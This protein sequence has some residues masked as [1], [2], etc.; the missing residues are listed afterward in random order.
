MRCWNCL[1]PI[2]DSEHACPDCGQALKPNSTQAANARSRLEYLLHEASEWDF[3]PPEVRA[4]LS[5]VYQRRLD[6]LQGLDEASE[7]AWPASDWSSPVWIRPLQ[8][9]PAPAP[10]PDS[11][12]P[13]SQGLVEQSLQPTGTVRDTVA[14]SRDELASLLP[15][16]SEQPTAAVA[17]QAQP[18]L[19]SPG[20]DSPARSDDSPL[21]ALPPT[22]EET[23]ASR[24]LGEADIRWFHSLGA[25]L[26]VAAVVGWLRATWDGY[27]KSLAGFMILL[28][29]AAMHGIALQLRKS[30]PLSARLLSILAGVL[31]PPAL[32]AVEIFD[33]LPPAVSGHDYW[34]LA[35]LVSASLLGLQA[36]TMK[37]KVPLYAGAVCTVMA[38]WSQG[39][40][41]TSVLCLLLGFVLG[42]VK[43][44]PEADE[45]EL[46][47]VAEL[48]KVGLA[49]GVFGC[50]ATL[51]L[52]RPE[53]APWVPLLAFTG[54]LIYLHLPTL[55]RQP[56]G[57]G[58]NRVA[59][60]AAITVLG[61]ALMR[62]ALDVPAPG[63]GL[64]ALLAAGLFLSARPEHEGGLLALRI[65]SVLGLVGLGIGFFTQ[66]HVPLDQT[67]AHPAESVM[68]FALAV[69]GAGLFGYLS[70]QTH[71]ESQ[72]TTLGLAALLATFGGW[73]H[74]FLL[75]CTP[76]H[77]SYF[78]HNGQ[79][80]PLLASFGLWVA[81][82]LLGSRWLRPRERALV[83]AVTAPVLLVATLVAGLSGLFLGLQAVVWSRVLF[84]LGAV[85]LAWER[86]LLVP[87]SEL[88]RD[89][90]GE[91]S[92]LPV[93][94]TRA[95]EFFLPRQVI[96]CLALGLA[97]AGSF[98]PQQ[99][100]IPMQLFGLVLLLS[101]ALAY[102]QPGLEM[103]WLVSPAALAV[104][105][106]HD[107]FPGQLLV[108]YLLA[109]A[110]WA[111]P[112][113]ARPVS[114]VLLVGL[115]ASVALVSIGE[116]AHWALLT[117]PMAYALAVATPV[118]GRGAW[119]KPVPAQYGF[120]LLLAVCL[121]CP[122]DLEPGGA[123]SFCLTALLPILAFLLGRGARHSLPG[124]FLSPTSPHALLLV[125][126]LWTLTQG[127]RESGL[128]LLV[129][130]AWAFQLDEPAT[131]KE[132]GRDLANGLAILGLAWMLGESH[133]H[134][135]LLVLAGGVLLS[136]GIA[137]S[138]PA[139][140]NPE[141]SD[142]ALLVWI[143][144]L[145]SQAPVASAEGG[146]A[147]L[148]GLVAGV[149]GLAGA[150]IPLILAGW[151]TFLKMADDQ[152]THL[153]ADF[154]IRLLPLAAVLIGSSL[155]MMARPEH[156]TRTALGV[157]PLATL[158][159]G[160]GLLA[161][162]PLLGLA[163]QADL[164]D[165][166]WVL[167]VGC[168]CLAVSQGFATLPELQRH[169]K[170]SGGWVLTGWAGVS[171]GRA[172]MALPWQLATLVVGL[173]LVAAGIK[174]EKS[175]KSKETAPP[176][177]PSLS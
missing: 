160:L 141:K 154:K 36:H 56:D 158:R 1:R 21:P 6:R 129:A 144:V 12:A 139:R 19:A 82:W 145:A 124:R 80:A 58:A 38:G 31:T 76:V 110:S 61:M 34:T 130:S 132:Y 168:S 25:L 116:A 51:F 64:Y 163:V 33:F 65:G 112:D 47:W 87:R 29:P 94:L 135:S 55:T 26:V 54:A 49:A 140:W 88:P 125:G 84:W 93:S 165:F 22:A 69:A 77:G 91:T 102:R 172:A 81:L 24:L 173:V 96:W 117:I 147:L 78:A 30:V 4:E 120:D 7:A 52:F 63:V 68:R 45:T 8:L 136:E 48:R 100:P 118:P 89:E 79:L 111:A 10:P 134:P 143:L 133:A 39:A 105:W 74:L 70:R 20:S 106:S 122:L 11:P 142:A 128:L 60:Q 162:P 101:P 150:R 114:L 46:A 123:P 151:L 138:V 119:S 177:P 14:L 57:S 37:E 35:F 23:L 32:L 104:Q 71:L 121:F 17:E 62:F 72:F 171:L 59:I 166:I 41:V 131:G 159:T 169:L 73:Y 66:A 156:P 5:G 109:A 108:F 103:A 164:T 126:F 44:G 42:P 95:L 9:G 15:A 99:I 75:A 176:D 53:Q 97:F 90:T 16:E 113:K 67:G 167:A 13:L 115:A 86:G 157:N 152:L 18:P 92:A 170:Q 85:A 107:P 27:G 137:L 149:R 148:A 83:G 175:R 28:S 3:L 98:T 161:I 2:S 155:W 43:A 40:L 153:D 174:A 127:Q 50:F 146:L